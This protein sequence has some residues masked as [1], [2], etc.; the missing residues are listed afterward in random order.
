MKKFFAASALLAFLLLL[1]WLKEAGTPHIPLGPTRSATGDA[2]KL[3]SQAGGEA[4]ERRSVRADSAAE[5]AASAISVATIS[6]WCTTPTGAP[7]VDVPFWL[8]EVDRRNPHM[9][10]HMQLLQAINKA[11]QC[12]ESPEKAS[13]GTSR[14]LTDR[15]GLARWENVLPHRTYIVAS[16]MISTVHFEGRPAWLERSTDRTISGYEPLSYITDP[17]YLEAG[18][19]P[20]IHAIASESASI[21]GVAVELPAHPGDRD[22]KARVEIAHVARTMEPD[23]QPLTMLLGEWAGHTD[24]QGRFQSGPLVPG[25]KRI[26]LYWCNGGTDYYFI[27]RFIDLSAGEQRDLGSLRMLPGPT[28]ETRFEFVDVAGSGIDLDQVLQ[29]DPEADK[30]HVV[31]FF[32]S[33]MGDQPEAF[34]I[35]IPITHRWDLPFRAHGLHPGQYDL[36]APMFQMPYRFRENITSTFA[37]EKANYPESVPSRM[38]CRITRTTVVTVKLDI[39]GLDDSKRPS[40]DMSLRALEDQLS[41]QFGFMPRDGLSDTEVVMMTRAAA[42]RYRLLGRIA[43]RPGDPDSPHWFVDELITVIQGTPLELRPTLRPG[44]IL[45]GTAEGLGELRIMSLMVVLENDAGSILWKID[46]KAEAEGQ[47]RIRGLP[48]QAEVR[49][50]RMLPSSIRL[51]PPGSLT[52]IDLVRDPKYSR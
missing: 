1:W 32:G 38:A 43:A 49:P 23:G 46:E 30:I 12:F 48:P 14:R 45:T 16:E 31:F 3:D 24:A 5:A 22:G 37:F 29:K 11:K 4:Y 17:L 8:V 44:A 9:P 39:Q 25:R 27:N 19:Q 36:S 10:E 13:E 40:V 26:T 33:Y 34:E 21:A 52:T 51:G 35:T 41:A 47:F 6:V 20:E 7:Q 50:F 42:G 18:A 28:F 15:D 2:A